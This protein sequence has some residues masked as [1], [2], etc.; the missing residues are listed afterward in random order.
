MILGGF[1]QT[2]NYTSLR[3][4]LAET[5]DQVNEDRAP[6]MITRQ[7]G[8]PVIMMSLAEYNALEE[9]A[10]LLRSPVNAE[11]LI[12]SIAHLRQGTLS[13]HVLQEE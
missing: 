10:Y 11:R 8:E 13:G 3:A 6:V 4:H 2:I 9:T 5:M 7:K 1:M 12:R